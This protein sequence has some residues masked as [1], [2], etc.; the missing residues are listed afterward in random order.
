MENLTHC[1][2]YFQPQWWKPTTTV[3]LPSSH[4]LLIYMMVPMEE[5]GE[6]WGN[7]I[8]ANSMFANAILK[9]ESS[10]SAA[11]RP[12]LVSPTWPGLIIWAPSFTTSMAGSKRKYPYLNWITTT[13]LQ[14]KGSFSCHP[15]NCPFML[16]LTDRSSCSLPSALIRAHTRPSLT[17]S[18]PSNGVCHASS[19]FV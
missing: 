7:D 5:K 16:I 13:L 1:W 15:R 6:S 4:K 3:L 2:H 11:C 10:T 17:L 19:V 8:G 12:S 18:S 9:A 14:C